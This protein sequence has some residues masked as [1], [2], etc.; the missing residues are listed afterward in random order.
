MS[1]E[2]DH[3]DKT[4]C[5][6][7]YFAAT[8]KLPVEFDIVVR[9]AQEAGLGEV[10]REQL[11]ALDAPRLIRRLEKTEAVSS[12]ASLDWETIVLQ[13]GQVQWN[14]TS[15]GYLRTFYKVA[16]P[17]ETQ[18]RIAYEVFL[19]RFVSYVQKSYKV[20]LLHESDADVTLF[21]P[22]STDFELQEAWRTFAAQAFSAN[23]LRQTFVPLVNSIRLSRRGYSTLDI[24]IVSH[25]HALY[26]AAFYRA[27]L[28][29]TE[30]SDARRKRERYEA[31][32]QAYAALKTRHS[33][34]INRVEAIVR[35]E[36]G[37]QASR[38]LSQRQNIVAKYVSEMERLARINHQDFFQVPPLLVEQPP[39]MEVRG[40]GDAGGE[41]CYACGR[42]FAEGEKKFKANK[43]IFESP[44]QRLQ[45]GSGQTEP[46]VCATC[47]AVSFVS[48][49]KTG[50]DRLVIRLCRR[51]SGRRYLLEDQLRML[52]MGELNVMAG[53]YVLLQ[54]SEQVPKAG[55][56]D[57]LSERMGGRQ[58]ALYK[59]ASLFGGDV[60]RVYQVE[61]VIGA[62][63]VLLPGRHLSG[64]RG[65][66]EVFGLDQRQWWKDKNLYG[67]VGQAVRYIEREEVVFAVYELLKAWRKADLLYQG[68]LNSVQASRLEQI[69]ETHWR[70]L[71]E[72]KPKEAT[73]FRDVAAMT[74]MLYAF[75]SFVRQSVDANQART[76]VRKL[77]ERAT[78]PYGFIY[79][80]AGN[81]KCK[82]ATLYR[83]SDTYFCFDQAKSLLDEI[84]VNVSER[85]GASDKGTPTLAFYF[86]DVVNAYTH[87]FENRYR[88]P[89]EQ[90][91][92]TYTLRLSLH[93]R[94]PEFMES[95]KGE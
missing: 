89:K 14:G 32:Y 38:Q 77:I 86:D 63:E 34:W 24:P 67:A 52:T 46:K 31:I 36:M 18:A 66:V 80:A 76:E 54:V 39:A 94:F 72:E 3:A 27:N 71:M 23:G 50:T 78:E 40:A 61:A 62:A 79:T 68:R 17:Q 55:G 60:F 12:A 19:D 22:Y 35:A 73:L 7:A 37:G 91:D 65:L 87:L 95:K 45:S 93:A 69:Y 43:F 88:S 75:C 74:G 84:G 85:E 81:T 49:I 30:E 29:S 1:V 6:A 57:P 21:V 64:V 26:L 5:L 13:N 41:A 15:I 59:V 28:A 25:D 82:L 90:R 20:A 58:Y 16:F 51:D 8:R 10:L 70:W 4:K 9:A 33:A 11:A 56:S 53:R 83:Q 92:F 42:V 44:S 2:M 48:P 47:A